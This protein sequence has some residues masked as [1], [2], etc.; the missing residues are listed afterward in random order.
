MHIQTAL[1]LLIS[2]YIILGAQSIAIYDDFFFIGTA[3][4]VIIIVTPAEVAQY[5]YDK[6]ELLAATRYGWLGLGTAIGVFFVH[7]LRILSFIIISHYLVSPFH[8]TQHS[9]Y[10]SWLC[11]WHERFLHC[12]IRIHYWIRFCLCC[13][14]TTV[15]EQVTLLVQ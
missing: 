5:S 9:V 6:A 15:Q 3:G 8:R 13:F 11:I 4:A 7:L 10:P 14:A 12:R 1:W 2:F